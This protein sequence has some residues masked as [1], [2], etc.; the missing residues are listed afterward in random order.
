MG[1]QDALGI[2]KGAVQE[3]AGR[4][5][6]HR[7]TLAITLQVLPARL[8]PTACLP[9]CLSAILSVSLSALLQLQ[10]HL[11]LS[12]C[13]ALPVTLS[14]SHPLLLYQA[15]ARWYFFHSFFNFVFASFQLF[16][17]QQF[18]LQSFLTRV[19]DK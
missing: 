18:F 4:C 5:W 7:D 16:F 13:L 3:K 2:S 15:K 1:R 14:L 12:R 9:V 19:K 17:A 10:L 11:R 6:Q 8:Y